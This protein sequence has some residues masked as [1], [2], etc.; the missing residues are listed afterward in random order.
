MIDKHDSYTKL[1]VKMTTFVTDIQEKLLLRRPHGCPDNIWDKFSEFFPKLCKTGEELEFPDIIYWCAISG[2][3]SLEVTYFN[4]E[5]T[6]YIDS[7]ICEMCDHKSGRLFS[8]GEVM[9]LLEE[10]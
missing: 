4:Q 6:F 1:G 8:Q 2:E 9:S 7:E 5:I 3:E 10:Q